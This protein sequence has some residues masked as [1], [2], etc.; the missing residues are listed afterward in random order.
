MSV[1]EWK[2]CKDELPAIGQTVL[3]L[4]KYGHISDRTFRAYQNGDLY[5]TPD[6]MKPVQDILYWAEMP[7]L[8]ALHREKRKETE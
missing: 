5:F 7:E 6:G 2:N 3:T 4:S 1:H 8:P